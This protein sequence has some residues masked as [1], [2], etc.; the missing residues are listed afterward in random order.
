MGVRVDHSGLPNWPEP[1]ADGSL[2]FVLECLL[3]PRLLAD[4]ISSRV[5]DC[6]RAHSVY[7]DPV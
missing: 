3:R 1:W 7:A 5:W 6:L 2:F 4:P